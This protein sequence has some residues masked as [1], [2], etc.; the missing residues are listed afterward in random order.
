LI[1]TS[2]IRS[3]QDESIRLI[4]FLSIAARRVAR[5][6]A[7]RATRHNDEFWTGY[8]RGYKEI[9][10]NDRYDHPALA[11]A[12]AVVMLAPK[13]LKMAVIIATAEGHIFVVTPAFG[14]YT[15]VGDLC[16]KEH[17]ALC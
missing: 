10:L 5:R 13:N 11:S 3:D 16:G 4:I 17:A 12:G 15:F 14:S 1:R 9:L 2:F 8:S 6:A 7:R